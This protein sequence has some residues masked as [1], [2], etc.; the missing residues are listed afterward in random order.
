MNLLAFLLTSTLAVP[1]SALATCPPDGLTRGELRELKT[2]QFEVADDDRRNR[3]AIALLGCLDDPDPAIRDG[4]VYEGLSSWLRGKALTND[5][6]VALEAS[7]RATLLG[8]KD[9]GGFRRP[10][11]ALVL[12]EVARADRIA[13]VFPDSVRAELVHT[14]ATSLS[15]IDDYRGFDPRDGWRHGVAHGADLIL[16]LAVNPKVEGEGLQELMSALATQIAPSG[17]VFYTFGE[18]ERLA[19]AVIFAYRRNLLDAAFWETW[20]AAIRSPSPLADWGSAFQTV[21][22]LAMRH[23]KIAFLLALGFAGRAGGDEAGQKLAAMAD[24]ALTQIIR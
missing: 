12:S 6:I 16:Q 20:V 14:A 24:Q 17:P 15:R 9:A 13:P 5:T 10:F 4:V 11:A 19:R 22:G 23:N 1:N 3:L 8:E 2:A 18:P 7:L 21:D